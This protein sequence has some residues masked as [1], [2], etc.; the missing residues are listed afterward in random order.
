MNEESADYTRTVASAESSRPALSSLSSNSHAHETIEGR[1]APGTLLNGR[2]RIIAL[3][4]KG[5]MGEVYRATDLT[6]GQSVALKF[7]PALSGGDPRWLER[8]HNEVRIAR[9][10][11]HPNVC[12]VYDIGEAEGLVFLSMEYVDGED[13]STLLRRIGRLPS[14]KATEIARKICA[15]LAAAHDRGVI[16]RDLKPHNVML[17]KRGEVLICDFGLAALPDQIDPSE[18]RQGT[19]AYMAPE[20]IKGIGVTAQSDI[21]ALGLVLY[22]LY[23]GKRPY[24]GGNLQELLAQQEAMSMTSMSSHAAD[25]EPAVENVIKRCL[26]P[27]AA[28][29]PSNALLVSMALPGGDPLA[30]AL[31]AGQTPSPELV[32][33]SQ[34]QGLR[35]RFSLP[36]LIF[37]ILGIL[38]YPLITGPIGALQYTPADLHPEALRVEARR[39]A[40]RFGYTLKPMDSIWWLEDTSEI[41]KYTRENTQVRDWY[42]AFREETPLRFYY[43]EAVND[44]LGRSPYGDVRWDLPAFERP[45]MVRLMLDTRGRLRFFEGMPPRDMSGPRGPGVRFADIVAATQFQLDE[46]KRIPPFRTPHAAYD[47]IHAYEGRSGDLLKVPVRVQYASHRGFLTSLHVSY[48]WSV[49]PPPVPK[50]KTWGDHWREAFPLVGLLVL[51]FYCFTLAWRNWKE[52]RADRRGAMRVAI[53]YLIVEIVV[54]LGRLHINFEIYLF[55]FFM[56][57][58]ADMLMGAA[59]MYLLYLALEPALRARWPQSIVTWSRVLSGRV[60]DPQVGAH[61]LS[62]AAM[63]VF[64]ITFLQARNFYEFRTAGELGNAGSIMLGGTGN[65]ISQTARLVE[66]GMQAGLVIFFAMFGLKVLFKKDWLVTLVACCILPLQESSLAESTHVWIDF[67][68][69][70]LIYGIILVAL[71]RFG[72]LSG[73]SCLCFANGL[74][75]SAVNIDF[76]VWYMSGTVA[77][78]LL[79]LSVV[80]FFFWRS[81][82]E[83][84][85]VGGST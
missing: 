17:N 55:Y 50:A 11:S 26:D 46:S 58:F 15:G 69:Y 31:A 65:W 2:Y 70:V 49:I 63:G 16:H 61:V 13:L 28:K 27:D 33:S 30:A 67:P 39:F 42:A 79:L 1:F 56:K 84:K 19:P 66:G 81:L 9:Q 51:L 47:E 64:L 36:L 78:M 6:L 80:I 24:T 57:A 60:L 82:G 62:G 29:R 43:R 8:F 75:R 71:M 38:T 44:T 14:E 34:S 53:A 21:Y 73:I 35:L 12:R 7:L 77:T 22:E 18:F 20:Q 72:L 40:G 4:G 76:T 85:L 41:V 32:A 10:V 3:L 74:G 52:G 54:Y 68:M 83:Q 23:T 37:V 59:L 25:I 45:M 48:P 5:G